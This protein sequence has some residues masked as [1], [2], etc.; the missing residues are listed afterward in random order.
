MWGPRV[1][2]KGCEGNGKN[3][4][5]NVVGCIYDEKIDDFVDLLVCVYTVSKA[6]VVYHWV[7][8]AN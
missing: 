4:G 6:T 2:R 7:Q 3:S 5:W 8:I 1:L